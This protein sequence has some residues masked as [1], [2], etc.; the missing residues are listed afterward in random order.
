MGDLPEEATLK[1]L[2]RRG[3]VEGRKPTL[4]ISAS[5]AAATGHKADYILTRRQD[6]A[7]YRHLILD[8]LAQFREATKEELRAMLVNKWP[9][10]FTAAQKENK[11]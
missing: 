3:L 8:Y 6:D 11:L 1:V 10:V 9:E 2:R 4:H 5:V 7:H